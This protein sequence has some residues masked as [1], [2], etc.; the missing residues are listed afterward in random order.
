[1]NDHRPYNLERFGSH[2]ASVHA[3]TNGQQGDHQEESIRVRQVG[4]TAGGR[5]AG[6]LRIAVIAPPFFP[7]PPRGYGGIERV[8]SQLVEGLVTAGHNVTL[9][10]AP[11][12]VTN[13]R[14][15]TPLDEPPPLGDPAGLP[16]EILHAATA[17]FAADSFDV[18]HDHT[19]VGPALAAMLEQAPPVV[20]TLHG[21]W[22]EP[23]RHLLGLISQRVHLVAISCA[24]RAANPQIRYAGVVHNGIDLSAYPF[25][26]HK[27]DFLVF[28][29]RISPEKRPEVAIDIARRTGLPLAMV[30]K[31][32]EPAERD[33]WN[34][35]VAPRLHPGVEVF[36]QPPHEVKVDLIGR[37]RAM[38]FPI[39]WP[40]PFGLVMPE[41]LACGTPVI[42]RSLGS[43]PEVIVDGV[44][45]FLC[46]DVDEMV[47]A[48]GASA[49][50]E[51]QSCRA[52]AERHFSAEAMVAGYEQ[53]YRAVRA[54]EEGRCE[55]SRPLPASGSRLHERA[56]RSPDGKK[57]VG[58]A[59]WSGPRPLPDAGD[60]SVA[61][62]P[63]ASRRI[64]MT[65]RSG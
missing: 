33:Y 45:G 43:A 8:V 46:R 6:P 4:A 29:G 35:I 65:E 63:E 36:E 9:F 26:P 64:L 61:G 1:M 3:S 55:H 62:Q 12:S 42:A 25:N 24:Q 27:D 38:I 47:D 11:G 37:A 54:E 13:A 39:D 23:N 44:T 20:H 32:S 21:P 53:I 28:V 50:L 14:L 40:E 16:D 2:D 7:L 49:D 19:G 51:P 58:Y 10:A 57:S 30:I 52:H 22:T 5:R 59:S 15:V 60:P 34:Q 18:I 56:A 17:Y 31:V 41:A 48:V